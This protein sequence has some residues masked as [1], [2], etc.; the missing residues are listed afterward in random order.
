MSWMGLFTLHNCSVSCLFDYLKSLLWVLVF[1]FSLH[2]I[3]KLECTVYTSVHKCTVWTP[4][5]RKWIHIFSEN[6][7][8]NEGSFEITKL[9]LHQAC[10]N[11]NKYKRFWLEIIY[12]SK[13]WYIYENL[14]TK[15]YIKY[16]YFWC[17]LLNRINKSINN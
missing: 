8:K 5:N 10:K 11:Y 13:W 12:L 16:M 1:W 4:W 3:A 15:Y 7:K 9:R 6:P 2:Y 14:T 17:L